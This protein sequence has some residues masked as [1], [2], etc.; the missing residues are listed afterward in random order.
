MGDAWVALLQACRRQVVMCGVGYVASHHLSM[1]GGTLHL[2]SFRWPPHQPHDSQ[3]EYPHTPPN[4]YPARQSHPSPAQQQ[5]PL[6][7]ARPRHNRHQQSSDCTLPKRLPG[8][9]TPPRP[10]ERRCARRRR[11]G[12]IHV[13]LHGRGCLCVSGAKQRWD[14]G[15]VSWFWFWLVARLHIVSGR[16]APVPPGPSGMG[17]AAVRHCLS[18]WAT[19]CRC[20]ACFH[21]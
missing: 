17:T 9:T 16:R 19:R 20:P 3:Q 12:G 4:S 6:L 21:G 2:S 10:L 8:A 5:R 15:L 18:K 13:Q 11:A 7:R 1:T 14:S